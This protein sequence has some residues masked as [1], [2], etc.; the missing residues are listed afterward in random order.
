MIIKLIDQ[1]EY[2]NYINKQENTSIQMQTMMKN[3]LESSGWTCHYL[4]LCDENEVVGAALISGKPMK[5]SGM[6]Y[7]CQYGPHIDYTNENHV[8]AFFSQLPQ[9]L[10]QLNA[11]KFE[12]NPNL[13]THTRTSNGELID[14]FTYPN[15]SILDE[16]GYTKQDIN[17]NTNGRWNIRFH[18]AKNLQNIEANELR[19]TY[20]SQA[21]RSVKKADQFGIEVVSLKYDETQEMSRLMKAS[22]QKHGFNAIDDDYYFRANKAFEDNVHFLVARLDVTKF[23][24]KSKVQAS[25]IETKITNYSGSKKEK[26]I[27]DLQKKLSSLNEN[28]ELIENSE[29][30]IDGYI[31][32]SAGVFLE[33][34]SEFI[35]LFGGNNSTYKKFC[36]SFALQDYAMKYAIENNF[37]DYNMYGIDGTFDGSDSVLRF[38]TT[39]NGYVNE[40]VGTYELVL[41]PWKLKTINFLKSS[42]K[43]FKK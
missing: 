41:K 39:F 19:N 23:L 32:M 9:V 6:F 20:G 33:N 43:I 22:A 40:F 30:I 17:L 24:E 13:I 36:S 29:D 8:K 25:E 21:K 7:T 28:I 10:K 4:G 37:T 12:F 31:T 3:M 35:Y 38:K 5:F 26:Q 15:L 11:C 16:L 14:T 34:N 42:I 2:I 27:P 1:N 18:Y